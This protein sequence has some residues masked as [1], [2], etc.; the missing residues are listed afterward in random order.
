MDYRSL[1]ILS[2][3]LQAPVPNLGQFDS[4]AVTTTVNHTVVA[5]SPSAV[6]PVAATPP[7]VA[8]PT[9]SMG[10][11]EASVNFSQNLQSNDACSPA[12]MSST[13][14]FSF[15]DTPAERAPSAVSLGHFHD[16]PLAPC[17][18]AQ[19]I[20][21]KQLPFTQ[22]LGG[23]QFSSQLLSASTTQPRG[24]DEDEFADF[25]AAPSG[26]FV[27]GPSAADAVG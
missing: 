11:F 6:T 26:Q 23:L 17:I 16:P 21:E 7:A 9:Q 5:V 8:I 14:G 20:P 15:T 3:C 10:I 24:T 25:Q 4:C 13:A 2:R 12:G 22:T 1:G 19:A 18:P 27:S